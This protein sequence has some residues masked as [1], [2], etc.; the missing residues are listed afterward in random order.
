VSSC[1][2]T[3][4]EK[5][6]PCETTNIHDSIMGLIYDKALIG[7]IASVHADIADLDLLRGSQ[8]SEGPTGLPDPGNHGSPSIEEIEQLPRRS[9]SHFPSG[10]RVRSLKTTIG[11]SRNSRRTSHRSQSSQKS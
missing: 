1:V 5:Q 2:K 4:E 8:A 3:Q 6:L 7:D 11:V 10:Q 9:G